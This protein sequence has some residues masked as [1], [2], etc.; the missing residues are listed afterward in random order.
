M[1]FINTIW[2]EKNIIW[3][4]AKNDCKA[5]FA[6]SGLGIVWAFLQPLMTILVFWFVFGIGFKNMPI[7][8]IPFIVWYIPA[9]LSWNYFSEGLL[10]VTNSLL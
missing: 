8:G 3:Q 1:K 4:L 10:Q 6:S 5:R 2:N 7:A 9:F